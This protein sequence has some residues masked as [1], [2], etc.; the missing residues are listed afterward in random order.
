MLDRIQQLKNGD[1]L[2]LNW[3]KWV[4]LL[5][6]LYCACGGTLVKPLACAT[7]YFELEG[8]AVSV[9]RLL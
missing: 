6:M 1:A 2:D 8:G 9:D 5:S 3:F 4:K 7:N